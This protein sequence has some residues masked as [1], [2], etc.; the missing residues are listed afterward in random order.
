[1]SP[2]QARGLRSVDTRS[3]LWSLAVIAY[4]C[5]V[6]SLPFVGEA[7]GDLLV[8]I[9]IAPAPVPSQHVPSLP[10]AF[11]AWVARA[12]AKDP[13]ERFQTANEMTE[14]LNAVTGGARDRKSVV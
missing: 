7:V 2:E 10:P 8:Q 14:A 6:G 3:D 4:R 13:A 12:L 9:C 5:V 1:M 11:D